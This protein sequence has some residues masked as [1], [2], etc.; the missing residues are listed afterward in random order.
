MNT[1]DDIY[2]RQVHVYRSLYEERKN[3]IC[4]I[5]NHSLA[6]HR[7]T[8]LA[9]PYIVDGDTISFSA[10]HTYNPPAISEPTAITQLPDTPDNITNIQ[11]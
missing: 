2:K 6:L 5:C 1:Q 10:T 7:F 3:S 8:D 11:S 4:T 9:C